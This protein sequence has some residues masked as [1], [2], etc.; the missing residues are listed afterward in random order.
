[1]ATS[2]PE[3]PDT[4]G[5]MHTLGI[6]YEDVG[7]RD[8]ALKLREQVLAL[9]RKVLGPEHP[10]TL[11]AM[12]DLASSYDEAGRGDEALKLR[13]QVVALQRE[14]NGP[15]HPDTLWA[16][17]NLAYSYDEAGRRDD[18]LKL[19]QELLVLQRK[20]KGPEHLDALWAMFD[21]ASSYDEVGRR[22]EALKLRE[23]VLALSRKVNG[24]EHPMTFWA[25]NNLATS[26]DKAGRRDDAL[27][28]R[29]ELLA[30]LDDYEKST[31]EERWP[32]LGPLHVSLLI[33]TKDYTAA[34]K[35]AEHLSD[36]HPENAQIQNELAW[37]MASDV[38]IEERDLTL[39]DKIATRAVEASRSADANILHTL[40]CV[41]FMEGKR[42]RAVTVEEQAAN[43]AEGDRKQA[44]QKT[45]EGYKRGTNKPD[46]L[47][48]Q[49]AAFQK[50]GKLAD[51]EA[52]LR[53]EL[54]LEQ[55]LWDDNSARWEDTVRNLADV[56]VD[57]HKSDEAGKLFAAILT[58]AFAGQKES[59]GLLRA[60]GDFFAR[61]GRWNEAAADFSRLVELEPTN[62]D[63]Y[64][65]LAPLLVQSGDLRGYR[66]HCAMENARFGDTKDLVIAER[67]AK[68]CLILADSGVDLGTVSKLAEVAASAVSRPNSNPFAQFTKGL[69]E[70]RQGRFLSAV[71]WTQKVLTAQGWPPLEAQASLVLAMSQQQLNHAG[72]AHT[73]LAKGLDIIK[74][75]GPDM[76]SGDLGPSWSDWLIA[77]ALLKEAKELIQ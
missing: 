42:D 69:A 75:D 16:M 22:D 55:N 34:Y 52:A 35:L 13:E 3:H 37:Q 19:R 21:L 26:Y 31:P 46:V 76:E 65:L 72:E 8:D 7:R 50:E 5:A 17:D 68:D 38:T 77:D 66:R 23:Q 73:A 39:A 36:T 10:D 30:K 20:V 47:S 29:Q 70:Y 25:M 58:P 64:R 74:R 57:E 4:L 33:C 9:E 44:F 59:A 14:V 43:L 6:F 28:L 62:H 41:L 49:A 15:E 32:D 71:E 40:A 24:P 27:K 67:T 56:L 53:E 12:F 48:R 61:H 54:A 2:G 51:A 63:A 45:L 18:A 60:G 1:L 11:W